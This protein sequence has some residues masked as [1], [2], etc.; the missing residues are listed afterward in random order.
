MWKCPPTTTAPKPSRN[1][2]KTLTWVLCIVLHWQ[3]LTLFGYLCVHYRVRGDQGVENVDIARYM[4]TVRGTDRGSFMSGKSV[5]NQRFLNILHAF[6]KLINRSIVCKM[7]LMFL[8]RG[9][10]NIYSYIHRIE[11]LWRDVR[12]CVTSKYY[13]ELH[14]LEMDQLL[15][16][17]SWGKG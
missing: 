16:V 11:R 1:L 4:F 5:H 6:T 3:I 2:G 17:S 12:T 14:S 9:W 7:S 13:N 15:D 8:L 10:K